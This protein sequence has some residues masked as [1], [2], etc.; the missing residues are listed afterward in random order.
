MGCEKKEKNECERE[1][2][3]GGLVYGGGGLER[4]GRPLREAKI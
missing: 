4:Y 2:Q 1:R 3:R